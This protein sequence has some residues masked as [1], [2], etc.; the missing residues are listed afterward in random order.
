[1]AK[2][3]THVV[4][5][6]D[7]YDGELLITVQLTGQQ[8]LTRREREEL[9]EYCARKV[10]AD[11]GMAAFSI[12][13]RFNRQA[14]ELRILGDGLRNRL[15]RLERKLWPKK[16]DR[17]AAAIY[18]VG[19]TQQAE[20]EDGRSERVGPA[21]TGRTVL[22]DGRQDGAPRVDVGAKPRSGVRQGDARRG[23]RHRGRE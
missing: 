20:D 12:D 22:G 3:K 17:Q 16:I 19:D 6:E 7:G 14:D 18:G 2:R 5:V 10:G 15:D 11:R 9:A 13:Q 21:R 23:R 8:K 1:M 4:K